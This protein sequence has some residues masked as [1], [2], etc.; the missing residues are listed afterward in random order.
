MLGVFTVAG[1]L[2]EPGLKDLQLQHEALAYND[3]E[4]RAWRD[5]ILD[6]AL[7]MAYIDGWKEA[8]GDSSL[9]PELIVAEIPEPEVVHKPLSTSYMDGE[10]HVKVS[11][12]WD[13]QSVPYGC[14]RPGRFVWVPWDVYEESMNDYGDAVAD[15]LSDKFGYAVLDWED[16]L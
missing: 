1:Q 11:V 3:E 16:S 15:W 10:R 14:V 12:T 2:A 4:L 6:K 13:T 5:A 7:D 8:T 9:P